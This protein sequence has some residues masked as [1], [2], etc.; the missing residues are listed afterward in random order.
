[1]KNKSIVFGIILLFLLSNSISYVSSNNNLN[2]TIY[3]DDEG[4][5][6]YTNIQDA[7][8]NAS[9]GDTIFVYSGIYYENIVIDKSINLIGENKNNTIIDGGN[10]KDVVKI[11]NVDKVNIS[12]FAILNSGDNNAG[13][14]IYRSADGII[15]N[16]FIVDNNYGVYVYKNAST[17]FSHTTISN[18]IILRSSVF[19][20]WLYKSSNNIVSDNIIS[21]GEIYGLGLCFWSTDTIVNGNIISNNKIM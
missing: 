2:K 7:I 14:Y 21:D 4:T 15:S 8:D 12:G 6:D 13:V 3:V 5:A 9:D 17:G 20:V 11:W 10:L 19:G 18:N 16:N 1:M